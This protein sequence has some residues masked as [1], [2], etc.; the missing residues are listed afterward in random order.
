MAG[1]EG[2][3]ENLRQFYRNTKLG[4]ALCEA[5]EMME[6]D[7]DEPLR[8]KVLRHFD[9]V[10]RDGGRMGRPVNFCLPT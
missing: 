2:L 10:R 1:G 6:A 8:E 3:P 4:D 9:Q 5:L 7:I